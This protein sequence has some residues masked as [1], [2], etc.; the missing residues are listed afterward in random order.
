MAGTTGKDQLFGETL[1]GTG[2]DYINRTDVEGHMSDQDRIDQGG[3]EGV[4]GGRGTRLPGAADDDTEGHK[5]GK[6]GSV[7]PPAADG[8]PEGVAGGRGTRLPGATGSDEDDV[9]G[10]RRYGGYQTLDG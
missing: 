8:G 2:G 5:I 6:P 3:P 10:H 9:E 7:T 4:A 1:P